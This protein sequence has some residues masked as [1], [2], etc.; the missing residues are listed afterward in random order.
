M[1]GSYDAGE[2]PAIRIFGSPSPVELNHRQASSALNSSQQGPPA[3]IDSAELENG[4][5][6]GSSST[7]NPP[8]PSSGKRVLRPATGQALLPSKRKEFAVACTV[9][10]AVGHH[11]GAYRAYSTYKYRLPTTVEQQLI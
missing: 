10:Y 1:N 4:D 8:P 3:D 7:S 11:V 9:A 2:A 5:A 6:E